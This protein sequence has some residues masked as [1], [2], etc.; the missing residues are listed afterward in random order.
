VVKR[1][2]WPFGVGIEQLEPL[3]CALR[4]ASLTIVARSP[5]S[6]LFDD[7]DDADVAAANALLLSRYYR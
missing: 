7:N 4:R 3:Q 1:C 6:G 5:H 2:A